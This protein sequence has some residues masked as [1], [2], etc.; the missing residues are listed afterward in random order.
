[1][2]GGAMLFSIIPR[3]VDVGVEDEGIETLVKNQ[4]AQLAAGEVLFQQVYPELGVTEESNYDRVVELKACD[5]Q[6]FSS[7]ADS[8]VVKHFGN[9]ADRDYH[10]LRTDPI[11]LRVS[12]GGFG[13]CVRGPSLFSMYRFPYD[14]PKEEPE[15]RT[16]CGRCSAW[17]MQELLTC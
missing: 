15:V 8:D 14:F 11:T 12:L 1:M 4:Y 2:G 10:V 5:L 16:C 3:V 6:A 13:E 17:C 7:F 9:S